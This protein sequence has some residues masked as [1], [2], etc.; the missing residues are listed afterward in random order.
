MNENTSNIPFV[1]TITGPSQSGKSLVLQKIKHLPF[2][3][4]QKGYN[5]DPCLVKKKTTRDYRVEEMKALDNGEEIDVEHVDV[6]PAECDLV[7][8]TYGKRYGINTNRIQELLDAGKSPYAVVNDIRAVEEIKEAFPNRVLSIFLFRKIPDLFDYTKEAEVRGNVSESE[9]NSRYEKAIAIYRMY[10]E[11]IAL[12]DKVILNAIEY[13]D[14]TLNNPLKNI[15]DRQLINVIC[16]VLEGKVILRQNSAALRNEIPK[17]FVLAGNAASGKDQLIRA[18][19][20]L[21]KM[22]AEIIPKFTTRR[23]EIDDEEE[24]ICRLRPKM[25]LLQELDEDSFSDIK[26]VLTEFD[27]V[28]ITIQ[29]R[30]RKEWEEMK[31]KVLENIPNG[32]DRFWAKVKESNEEEIDSLF[33]PNPAYLDLLKL[34]DKGEI[35]ETEEDDTKLIAFGGKHYIVYHAKGNKTKLYGC[36]ISPTLKDGKYKVLVASQYG[37]FNILKKQLGVGN[38][39]VIY[40]HSQV[41]ESEFVKNVKDN[42]EKEKQKEF[43]KYLDDYVNNIVYYDHVVIY[44]K[45]NLSNKQSIKDEELTDQM[46]RLFRV[47]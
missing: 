27:K 45:S 32:K 1:I 3:L 18:I 43:N 42:A 16:G 15:L 14:E 12:F 40:S 10:I 35:L 24:M 47:Y 36:E 2:I 6:I 19:K 21:G 34:V 9:V 28:S 39:A 31:R 7:Y 46:F 8:Q 4:S 29:H 37:L 44:A 26:N 30:F 22:Q 25:E 13:D 11:N 5:F 20:D 38:V 33:E 17:T 41:S 23:Q